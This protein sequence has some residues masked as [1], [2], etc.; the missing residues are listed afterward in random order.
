MYFID[1]LPC[2]YS[3]G[4]RPCRR[5][6]N[7]VKYGIS[8][9]PNFCSIFCIFFM[10]SQRSRSHLKTFLEPVA[11]FSQSISPFRGMATPFMPEITKYH[12][13]PIS[14]ITDFPNSFSFSL[15]FGGYFEGV[16]PIS[17][18]T[19]RLPP[20]PKGVVWGSIFHQ[21]LILS[22]FCRFQE[23]ICLKILHAYNTFI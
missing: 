15:L 23:V 20:S 17:K 8:A 18:D 21:R 11:S 22:V 10:V 12:R 14:W 7:T 4:L 2:I 16:R 1:L 6:Q 3:K 19:H 13:T 5:P 9:F